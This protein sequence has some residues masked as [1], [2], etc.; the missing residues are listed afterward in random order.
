MNIKGAEGLSVQDIRSEIER[1]GRLVVYLYVVSIV[2]MSFKQ[3][4]DVHLIRAG[5][6][7]VLRG[8][9]STLI[10]LVCGWWGIPW[11]FI[12]TIEAFFKN[13]SGGVDITAEWM[14]AT[15]SLE[16][17]SADM[18]SVPQ[19]EGF[20]QTSQGMGTTATQASGSPSYRR[21][22]WKSYLIP[23]CILGAIV[24]TAIS[25]RPLYMASHHPV[26]L[27]NGLDVPYEVTIGEKAY[28][29]PND[30][31]LELELSEDEYLVSAKFPK[32]YQPL[33][34][35]KVDL[36]TDFGSRL[37]GK[38]IT[39]INP[40][41]LALIYRETTRYSATPKANEEN[42]IGIMP[43]ESVIHMK[44]PDYVLRD[45]P[46]SIQVSD[47]AGPTYKTRV[48]VLSGLDAYSMLTTIKERSSSDRASKYALQVGAFHPEDMG[49]VALAGM[50]IEPEDS[51]AFFNLHLD[52]RPILVDWHRMYQE[53]AKKKMPREKLVA[54]YQAYLEKE[55]E[56]GELLYLVGRL[57]RDR[58]KADEYYAK[59][60]K[61]PQPSIYVW[62]A[63]G[64]GNASDG[65]FAE[66]LLCIDK[67]LA[68][69][70]KSASLPVM[71]RDMLVALG[72]TK[73][74]YEDLQKIFREDSGNLELAEA[75][76][77]I[78]GCCGYSKDKVDALATAVVKHVDESGDIAEKIQNAILASYAYGK[79]DMYA[80]VRESGKASWPRIMWQNAISKKQHANAARLIEDQKV[81][82]VPTS[83]LL[84]YIIAQLS[85]DTVAADG[86]F[87][88]AVAAL[89]EDDDW[90]DTFTQSLLEKKPLDAESVVSSLGS[91]SDKRVFCCALGLRY[92]AQKDVYFR[93]ARQMNFAPDFPKL[94]LDEVLAVDGT[95]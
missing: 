75:T 57:I 91:P 20:V 61:A 89:K 78:A 60:L 46:H 36:R 58:K 35:E 5:Q 6:S 56:N 32:N 7:P 10:S 15:S 70:N 73:E 4:T 43:N 40:D 14:A 83:W 84:L 34:S 66:A 80:F 67:G 62:N 26:I 76:A 25:A 2:V 12:Y 8:L 71:R 22:T 1:G 94:L 49:A 95:K 88:K 63:L 55:P 18:P 33:F 29:V 79:G 68:S 3:N 13:L 54:K 30:K 77:L 37:F 16:A 86:Y 65:K 21:K 17:Q 9:P 47:K 90:N 45:F 39:L 87:A 93:C 42:S 19:S 74:V 82:G 11:G 24:V 81:F 50:F 28:T 92:P 31:P 38:K 48:A 64:Y 23:V 85:N 52:T 41:K 51:P 59:A 72:R 69:G 53:Y 27:V 44:A